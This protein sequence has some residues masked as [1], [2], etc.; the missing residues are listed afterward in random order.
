MGGGGGAFFNLYEYFFK[1]NPLHEFFLCQLIISPIEKSLHEFFF[2]NFF[3]ARIFFSLSVFPCAILFLLF[4][5]SSHHFS[6]GLPL[7]GTTRD[8]G[9]TVQ[10]YTTD[11]WFPYMVVSNVCRW[12]GGAQIISFL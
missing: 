4:P 10:D 8:T 5:H 1:Y 12:C 2:S 9:Y 3:G 6:N 11:A 7:I